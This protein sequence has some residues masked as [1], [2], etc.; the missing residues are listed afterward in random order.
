MNQESRFSSQTQLIALISVCLGLVASAQAAKV[1]LIQAAKDSID[2]QSQLE[3]TT[4][5]YGL[6][7]KAFRVRSKSDT[8]QTIRELNNPD[9]LAAVISVDAMRQ[10]THEEIAY[11]L[12]RGQGKKIPL[13]LLGF[14]PQ[15]GE[16][17]LVTWSKGALLSCDTLPN[18]HS[19]DPYIV[20]HQ[21]RVTGSIADE[22]IPSQESPACG[23]SSNSEH[24]IHT[25]LSF[26]ASGEYKAVF[27]WSCSESQEVFFLPAMASTRSF[28]G[29]ERVGFLEAFSRL[30]PF[31]MFIRYAA[32]DKAWHTERH[33]ANLTIDD[34]WLTEP[35]GHLDFEALL[36]EMEAHRFHT[37][38]AFIPWNFDRSESKVTQ[39]F[40]SHPDRFSV[41][42]H[43]NNHDHVEFGAYENKPLSEQVVSI[44]QAISRMDRFQ[45]LTGIPFNAVMIF[46]QEV[47]P[48][49][50]T[51]IKLKES[52]FLAAANA[53][54]VP[55][56]SVAPADPL[57]LLRAMNVE[58]A[59]FALVRRYP[60]PTAPSKL[61]IAINYFLD[62]P[63]LFYA[64]E[65]LFKDGISAFDTTA[66]LIN[67]VDPTTRWESLGS[68]MQHLYLLK[69]RNNTNYDVLAYSPDLVLH[70]PQP[71]DA[72]FNVE[73]RE[74][75]ST[76][77]R[78]VTV[79]G[80]L[81]SYDLSAGYLHLAVPVTGGGSKHIRVE[82]RSEVVPIDVS[83]RSLYIALLRHISDFRDITLSRTGWGRS[84]T[85]YYYANHIDIWE[86]NFERS[87]RLIAAFV[88][89]I[90]LGWL[91]R[92]R[93]RARKSGARKQ[94]AAIA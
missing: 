62:N 13:L 43:G 12:R 7:L 46:P 72:V 38:I 85:H 19:N 90:C 87:A 33:Y 45:T 36:T 48:P 15:N 81:W 30:A 56:D 53:V 5:F 50:P 40:L 78:S 64:H 8:R 2:T 83:K 51:L 79:D 32:G 31:M 24:S 29:P 58:Y 61:F 68:V 63:L 16:R 3:L 77:I 28:V 14:T 37:T 69:A 57:F 74:S 27:A 70:N 92:N 94:P 21:N 26:R 52:N 88:L 17:E 84:I 25:L 55:L 86:L 34:A 71:R 49:V 67:Q 42:V 89:F 11:A 10:F 93:H 39:V 35:Y 82:Y 18:I 47:A 60:V 76:V 66:D 1:V 59:D 22:E 41:S 54:T 80:A 44:R 6:T 23:F 73:K 4:R 65:N 20:G 91:I 75:T 9:A